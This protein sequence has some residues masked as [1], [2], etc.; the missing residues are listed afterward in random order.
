MSCLKTRSEIERIGY[1][2]IGAALDVHTELVPGLLESAYER[3]LAYEFDQLGLAYE[4][5][6]PLPIRY[7]GVSLDCGYRLD[8]LVED[9]VVIELK[10]VARVQDI[11]V[12]Q[13]LSYLK[14]GDWR[15]G[16]ILNFKVTRMKKG[17]NRIV[18]N[19]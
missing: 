17:I 7:K 6:K 5:Q 18:N 13:A 19:L 4:R 1:K 3:C 9:A 15:L 11:H 12:A 8:F 16:Y 10:T 2:V 14:L